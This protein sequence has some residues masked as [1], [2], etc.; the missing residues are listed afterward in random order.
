MIKMCRGWFSGF[1][2]LIALGGCRGSSHDDRPAPPKAP[3]ASPGRIRLGTIDEEEL[4]RRIQRLR[5]KVVLVDYWATW[6]ES[7]LELLPHT[8][9]L[10]R[11]LEDRGLAVIAVGLDDEKKRAE[12]IDDLTSRGATFEAYLSKYGGSADAMVR[13]G[14]EDST[15]PNLKLYDRRGRLVKTF[16]GVID[17]AGIDRAVEA[18]LK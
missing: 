7:C 18:A 11:R 3:A 1:V 15:L 9:A 8:Q 4:A 17:P 10:A 6:C 12:E 2:V 5:G 13:F 16:S 14:I